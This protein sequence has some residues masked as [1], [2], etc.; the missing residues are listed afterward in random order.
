MMMGVAVLVSVMAWFKESLLTSL[1]KGLKRGNHGDSQGRTPGK[2]PCGL[3]LSKS[4][5]N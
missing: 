5:K 3:S 4:G 1:E 2:V